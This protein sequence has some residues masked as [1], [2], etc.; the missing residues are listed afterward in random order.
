MRSSGISTPPI[1][2]LRR[3]GTGNTISAN[4]PIATV[5]P[6]DGDRAPGRL[7][8]TDDRVVVR[9]AVL[10]F[11]PPSGHEKQA[12]VDRQPEPD[13]GDEELD[14]ERHFGDV[15][16]AEHD[17]ERREDRDRGDISGTKASSEA[18]TKAER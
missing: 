10:A 18:K 13:E 7:R 3:P 11:L 12:V 6:G 17:E 1:P 8:R 4:R 2:T 15:G 14:D 9:Q 16:E 5:N